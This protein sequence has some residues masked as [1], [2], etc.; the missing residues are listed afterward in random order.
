MEKAHQLQL[1]LAAE[2]Q[3]AEGRLYHS[4]QR[5]NE[6]ATSLERSQQARRGLKEALA[7]EQKAHE[8]TRKVL[9]NIEQG[10]RLRE[11]EISL[12][13]ERQKAEQRN[14]N[15]EQQVYQLQLSLAAN[16]QA[17]RE[18]AEQRFYRSEERAYQLQLSLAAERRA[19][20]D[21]EG[22][23]YNSEQRSNELEVTLAQEQKAHEETRKVLCNIEQG[24][25]LREL[26]MTYLDAE[27][28]ERKKLESSLAAEQKAYEEISTRTS[29]QWLLDHD[30][31]T[32]S[33]TMR[34]GEWGSVIEG[35]FY[36]CKVAVK[37]VQRNS[38]LHLDFNFFER[39]MQIAFECR[40]PCLLQFIGA[41]CDDQSLVF[42]SELP[43]NSLKAVLH[44]RPLES[45]TEI[46]T[47]ALHVAT[48]LNYLHLRRP[49]PVVHGDISSAT[50][51][52]IDKGSAGWQAKISDFCTI[53]FLQQS[54]KNFPF[55]SIYAAP[56]AQ[57]SRSP[58]VCTNLVVLFCKM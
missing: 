32:L 46:S 30:E 57:T 36:D 52:L 28:Q 35:S 1:S 33:G 18:D 9:R 44:K 26:E 14:Y 17:I 48:G 47:I 27:R 38:L 51:L 15:S 40:H 4:Q 50:V 21:A 43:D 19:R 12:A 23:V 2:R 34:D 7:E 16:T 56:E 37:V 5:S 41:T 25:R 45:A 22:R 49:A 42:V 31:I 13:A 8:E 55:N 11:L 24:S 54:M 6:L 10:S 39:E 29:R 3:D 20:E 58:K 53:N